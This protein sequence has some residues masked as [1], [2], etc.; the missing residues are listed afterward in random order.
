MKVMSLG[1][2]DEEVQTLGK[3]ILEKISSF[4][5]ASVQHLHDRYSSFLLKQIEGLDIETDEVLPQILLL[6]GVIRISH[7]HISNLKTFQPYILLALKNTCPEGQVSIFKSIAEVMLQWKDHTEGS[8]DDEF[9]YLKTFIQ[10]VISPY[11]IWHAG[12]SAETVRTMATACLCATIQGSSSSIAEQ[13]ITHF[14]TELIPLIEDNSVRTRTLSLRILLSSGPMEAD[15]L[16]PIVFQVSAR[17]D[18]PCAEVRELAGTCL[19]H[20]QPLESEKQHWE[21]IIDQIVERMILHLESPEVK[22]KEVLA[23][24][25]HQ[26]GSAFP[27]VYEKHLNA[28]PDS[29]P[30]KKLLVK[31]EE[32]KL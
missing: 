13:L 28:L 5:Y 10:E 22:L 29:N 24:S 8:A 15:K 26:I 1:T 6:S 18:D 3:E 19:G 16:K 32:T 9:T 31:E 30:V 7:L 12:R 17:L 21:S 20:V 4:T 2:D 14:S 25:L 23:A 11:L 27:K